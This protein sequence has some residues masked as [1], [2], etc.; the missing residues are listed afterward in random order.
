MKKFLS[1]IVMIMASA[2][3]ASA[4]DVYCVVGTEGLTGYS[5][6]TSQNA[7]T[8]NEETGLYE[9]KGENVVVNDEE[10]P[11]FKIVMNGNWD[12]SWPGSNW[13]ITPDVVGGTGTFNITITFNAETKEIGVTGENTEV[14][15]VDPEDIFI[16]PDPGTDI[17]AVLEGAKAEV[18]KV[19][20]IYIELAE[21]EAYTLS[22][23][24]TVPNNFY[25]W[26][27]DATITVDEAF[28]GPF[29]TIEGS[30]SFYE[31][32]DGSLSDHYLISH[33]EIMG[34][35]IKGLQGSLVKDN[36]K[37]LVQILQIGWCNIEMPA[38]GK[39]VIDFNSKGYV[40]Y[41]HVYNSTIW[42][43]Q[44][45]TGFFAQYGSRPKNIDAAMLQ[46]FV[47]ENNT[48]VNIA[49]GK[50]FNDLKQK[51]TE[52]NIFIL[53]NNI[54]VDCGKQ[55]QVIVGMDGGQTSGNPVWEVD[56]NYFEWGG[57]CVNAAELA[58]A[59]Q[60]NGE[61]IA[62]NSVEGKIEFTDADNGDFSFTFTMAEGYVEPVELGAPIWEETY[63]YTAPVYVVAGTS[64]LCGDEWNTK[65]QDNVMA[66]DE[67]SGLYTWT[68]ENITVNNEIVPEFKVVMNANWDTCWPESNWVITPDYAG[69]EGTYTVTITYNAE[70]NEI[71]VIVVDPN[72]I[73]TAI[74][75]INVQENNA[76]IYN[77]QGQRVSGTQKGLYIINGKKVVRK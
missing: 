66:Y 72:K 76:V 52:Q 38:A 61:D 31:K 63:A 25:L 65:S 55:N 68:R 53:K 19:G 75:D 20:D 56:G 70:T 12:T 47:F 49:N 48:I 5:W 69:G 4:Q 64:S 77:L 33:F 40:E 45:N 73:P 14:P 54:F 41:L 1:F 46:Q 13:V 17:F 8:L 29:V 27:N 62:Q 42:A 16:T 43:K 74:S 71:G 39:N 21:N 35:T 11:E 23:T 34:V 44:F 32:P 3:Y 57:E 58:K 9:W 10:K 28:T 67:A 7:M 36:Q 51:G 26:G 18:G 59:G 37:T 24:I 15:V 30:E 60:K 2:M 6:D 22:S 50:N